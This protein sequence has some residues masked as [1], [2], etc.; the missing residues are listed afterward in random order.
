MLG[1]FLLVPLLVIAISIPLILGK[2]PRNHWYGFRTPKT[3]SSDAVWYPANRIGGKYLCVAG[4]IQ[5][6]A[7]AIGFSFWPEQT[8]AYE[9]VL[10][11]LPLLIAVLF[12]FLAIRHI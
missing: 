12:W 8:I 10:A 2:V 1:L 5:L 11:T 3:L 6:I 7:F 9:S 4:M